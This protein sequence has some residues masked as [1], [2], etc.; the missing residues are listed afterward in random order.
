MINEL[1]HYTHEM[2]WGQAIY[3]SA[4][5]AYI[6]APLIYYICYRKRY[7]L[8]LKQAFSLA[9]IMMFFVFLTSVV[10]AWVISGFRDFGNADLLR[11]FVWV[12]VFG[13]YAAKLLKLPTGVVLDYV[14]PAIVLQ[15]GVCHIVCPF[16]GCCAG[17]PCKWG[18]WNPFLDE[19]VFPIQ[20][21]T[22]L[23]A[24]GVLVLILQYEKQHEYDG[25]GKAYP[26]FLIVYGIVR[27][28]LEFLKRSE[29]IF[30]GISELGLQAL[31]MVLVG[32]IWIFTMH[33]IKVEKERKAELNR[34]TR[35]E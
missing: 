4:F 32:T 23:V 1:I 18:I 27:F 28:F 33:E 16:L 11:A 13:V 14:A 21:V 12:P 8:S 22:C 35:R 26:I 19:M 5:L 3:D 17:I 29:K 20:W 9:A 10:I 6:I 34:L 31:F 15:H 7:D 30:L 25:N 24:A 2:G